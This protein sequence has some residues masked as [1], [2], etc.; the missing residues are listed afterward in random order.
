MEVNISNLS[1]KIKKF[2][3]NGKPKVTNHAI[4]IYGVLPY[5]P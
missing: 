4:L 5:V 2:L 3:Y 1:I